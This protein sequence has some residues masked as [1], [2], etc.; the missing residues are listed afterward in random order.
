MDL[1]TVIF[2]DRLLP[3]AV[4]EA[5][6]VDCNPRRMQRPDLLKKI[7]RTAIIDRV[8]HIQAHNM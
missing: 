7:K 3:P 1:G 6:Q 5:M 4:L 2:Q 8:R